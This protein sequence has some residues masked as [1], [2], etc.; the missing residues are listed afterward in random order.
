MMDRRRFLL[1]S[2]AGVLAAPRAADAQQAGKIPTVVSLLP[3]PPACEITES[4]E[5]LRRP[6]L[7]HSKARSS[8]YPAWMCHRLPQAAR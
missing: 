6:R 4:E 5:S 3:G 8:P 1:T 2:L 7:G